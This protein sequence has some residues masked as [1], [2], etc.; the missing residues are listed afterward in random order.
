MRIRLGNGLLPM[1]A[2]VYIMVVII[3]FVPC[4]IARII[5]GLPFVLIFPGYAF[6]L[7]LFPARENLT[8]LTRL[9]FS[10]VL[11][12]TAAVILGLIL[13]F[14]PWGLTV[15]SVLAAMVA[16]IAV[17][18]VIAVL[19]QKGL[20]ET[21]RI[22]IVFSL[23]W[24]Q[25]SGGARVILVILA[26]IVLGTLGATVY[27]LVNPDPGQKFTEFYISGVEDR[28]AYPTGLVAGV[29]QKMV[30]TVVN[31]ERR[32]LTYLVEVRI[33]GEPPGRT[34][35]LTLED[36][37]RCDVTVGFTP[38]AAG[39]R[40]LVEFVLYLEGGGTPYL[41]PLRLWVDVSPVSPD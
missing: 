7:A 2:L 16:C 15:N 1:I 22:A 9:A 35:P 19:R 33:N 36:G 12:I 37:Q 20:P 21:E 39:E 3:Y 18:S 14:T 25:R 13:N 4:D 6:S 5:L 30:I 41:E 31:R 17:A 32:T 29:E 11:S 28:S 34:V 26:L 8:G 27:Y 40:Q 24:H 23:S 38:R 10:I